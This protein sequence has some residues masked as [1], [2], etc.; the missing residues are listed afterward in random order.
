MSLE[1]ESILEQQKPV[2]IPWPTEADGL[3]AAP[4]G[5]ETT[6]SVNRSVGRF[7]DDGISDADLPFLPAEQYN[8]VWEAILAH[9]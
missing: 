4:D 2:R 5:G 6:A 3:V 8:S 7:D 1:K 9:L